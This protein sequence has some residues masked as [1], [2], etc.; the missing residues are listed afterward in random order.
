MDVGGLSGKSVNFFLMLFHHSYQVHSTHAVILQPLI[1][2]CSLPY[3]GWKQS[4]NSS[5]HSAPGSRSQCV[6]IGTEDE[7]YFPAS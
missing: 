6:G 2:H 5:Q 1:D 4:Q 3:G 7:I